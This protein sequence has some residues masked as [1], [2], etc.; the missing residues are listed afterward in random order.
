M[1][2]SPRAGECYKHFQRAGLDRRRMHV[3]VRRTVG[4]VAENRMQ[5]ETQVENRD[6]GEQGRFR[7]QRF[8]ASHGTC[9]G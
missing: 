9:T 1:G 3:L 2:K 6:S 4:E 8:R 7:L 5:I